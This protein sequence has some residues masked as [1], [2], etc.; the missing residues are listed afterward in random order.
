[1]PSETDMDDL[2]HQLARSNKDLVLVASLIDKATNLGGMCR[3]CEIFGVK[4]LVVNCLRVTEDRLF[5]D[6][7]MTADK[8]LN[9]KEVGSLQSIF[10]PTTK[11][12]IFNNRAGTLC[13]N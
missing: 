13:Q 4:E 5:K 2:A 9:I 10:S 1:M 7:A 12:L 8:W 6:L 3:T 11:K